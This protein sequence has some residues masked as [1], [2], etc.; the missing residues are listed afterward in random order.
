MEQKKSSLT[1]Q[2]REAIVSAAIEAFREY[3]VQATSMDKLAKLANVSKRTIYNHFANK[4]ALVLHL[5]TELWQ[6]AISANQLEYQA[7]KP[8][9]Q[10][11]AQLLS[12]E[13]EF[14][15]SPHYQDLARVAF[16]HL[17]DNPAL[18][19]QELKK[20]EGQETAVYRW[21]VAATKAGKLADIDAAFAKEQ[22]HSLIKGSA[23]WPQ[24]IRLRPPLSEAQKQHLVSETTKLFLARYRATS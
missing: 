13:V 14:Y 24:L 7:D 4:E 12:A 11:L 17:F 15:A 23:L 1:E 22:L 21:L 3:G 8:L 16:D 5:V 6:R 18:F 9:D 20:L 10:Q 19:E 2:K